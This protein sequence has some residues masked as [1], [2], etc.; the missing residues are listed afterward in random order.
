MSKAIPQSE[1]MA[2]RLRLKRKV[3]AQFVYAMAIEGCS[4]DDIDRRV[5]WSTGTARHFVHALID[6]T[7]QELESV[8]DIALAMGREPD[9]QLARIDAPDEPP[10]STTDEVVS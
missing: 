6:G 1:I 2:A 4:W 9:F 5:G 8:S 3:A 10:P 7:T